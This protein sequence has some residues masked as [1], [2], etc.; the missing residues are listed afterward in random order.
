[1]KSTPQP[2]LGPDL[3]KIAVSRGGL[4]VHGIVQMP[5]GKP[6]PDPATDHIHP[7]HHAGRLEI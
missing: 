2:S 1:M 6:V 5:V 7:A 3:W 4:L